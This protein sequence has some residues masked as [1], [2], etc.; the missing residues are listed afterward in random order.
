MF[1]DIRVVGSIC[2][3][4]ERSSM[5]TQLSKARAALVEERH[6]NEAKDVQIAILI[7]IS[8]RA[9]LV[10]ARQQA[11]ASGAQV[12]GVSLFMRKLLPEVRLMIYKY[13]LY[14]PQ[15]RQKMWIGE[16]TEHSAYVEP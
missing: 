13:L 1:T 4:C 11:G 2:A 3:D 9:Q 8:R 14:N 7:R 15:L 16:N 10:V 5:A 12:Q 6:K